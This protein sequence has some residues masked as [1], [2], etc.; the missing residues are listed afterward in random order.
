MQQEWDASL[1]SRIRIQVEDMSNHL[2]MLMPNPNINVTEDRTKLQEPKVK[3][4]M[5]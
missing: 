3:D 5:L 2:V 1:G 4:I